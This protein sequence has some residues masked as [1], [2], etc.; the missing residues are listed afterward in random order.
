M[1]LRNCSLCWE[2]HGISGSNSYK[3]VKSQSFK[4]YFL[5]INM[6][7][8]FSFYQQLLGEVNQFTFLMQKKSI[9]SCYIMPAVL[10]CSS[11]DC[12][13]VEW[14]NGYYS[15][16]TNDKTLPIWLRVCELVLKCWFFVFPLYN[17]NL[18]VAARL[19]SL[20]MD[21]ERVM[22]EKLIWKVI[23]QHYYVTVC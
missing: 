11:K 12:G 3:A 15:N 7:L 22:T 10:S 14:R 1:G 6:H 21:C 18:S 4:Q 19:F 8:I 23:S 9:K 20:F 16:N 5:C 2:F 13:W 17:L